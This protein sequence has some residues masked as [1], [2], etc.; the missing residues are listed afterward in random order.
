MDHDKALWVISDRLNRLEALI[1][2]QIALTHH[3]GVK[4]SQLTDQLTQALTDLAQSIQADFAQLDTETAA[5]L[6]AVASNDTAAIQAA[7][8][9]IQNLKAAVDAKVLDAQT[10][11]T[12]PAPPA[13]AT[14]PATDTPPP[15]D[16]TPPATS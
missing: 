7:V 5:I 4:M 2:E 6:A 9:N 1:I 11:L 15:A 12:P 10:K 3:L 14:P 8:A 13:D 16:T